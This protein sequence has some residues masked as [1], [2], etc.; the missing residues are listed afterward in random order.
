MRLLCLS[1][2][3]LCS[4]KIECTDIPPQ[5]TPKPEVL[6]IPVR[7]EDPPKSEWCEYLIKDQE[8]EIQRLR[9]IISMIECNGE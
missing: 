4:C 1:V 8:A 6:L 5:P 2:I 7:V 3:L 9:G